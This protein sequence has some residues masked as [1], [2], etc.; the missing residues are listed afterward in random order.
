MIK[1]NSRVE[2]RKRTMTYTWFMEWL[3]IAT[4]YETFLPTEFHNTLMGIS[5]YD[6]G[7]TYPETAMFI[8]E[9]WEE[10]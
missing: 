4:E 2:E 5:C 6:R 9:I 7:E 1:I 10:L 8:P 3:P